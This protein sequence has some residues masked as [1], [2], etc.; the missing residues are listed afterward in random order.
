MGV[1]DRYRKRPAGGGVLSRY[2]KTPVTRE[3]TTDAATAVAEPPKGALQE[4]M[5][6]V[7]APVAPQPQPARPETTDVRLFEGQKAHTDIDPGVFVSGQPK[8]GDVDFSLLPKGIAVGTAD[9]VGRTIRGIE[10]QRPDVE[11]EN[12]PTP[13]VVAPTRV[14]T[15][16]QSRGLGYGLNFAT[17]PSRM[18]LEPVA[19]GKEE[20]KRKSDEALLRDYHKRSEAAIADWKKRGDARAQKAADQAKWVQGLVP[21]EWRVQVAEASMQNL[22]GGDT[23]S[24]NAW[25]ATVGQ[26]L[27]IIAEAF[28]AKLIGGTFGSV[29]GPGGTVAGGAAA[30]VGAMSLMESGAFMEAADALGIDIDIARKYAAVYGPGSGAIEYAQ[31]LWLGKSLGRM[32]KIKGGAAKYAIAAMKEIA[33]WTWEGVEELSQNTLENYF[34]QKAAGEHNL[35]HSDQPQIVAPQ[36]GEGGLRAFITG[37]G[38]AAITRTGGRAIGASGR[39]AAKKVREIRGGKKGTTDQTTEAQ[40]GDS[41][42]F[43]METMASV[44]ETVQDESGADL[45]E[46]TGFAGPAGYLLFHIDSRTPGGGGKAMAAK[47]EQEGLVLTGEKTSPVSQKFQKMVARLHQEGEIDIVEAHS[48]PINTH[49]GRIKQKGQASGAKQLRRILRNAGLEAGT[50]HYWMMSRGH[51]IPVKVVEANNIQMPKGWVRQG[52]AYVHESKISKT[53]VGV[54]GKPVA[55]T[56]QKAPKTPVP[57]KAP[58]RPLGAK[59]EET[60]AIPPEEGV[61]GEAKTPEQAR[62]EEWERQYNPP[63]TLQEQIAAEEAAE[64]ARAGQ[65][66]EGDGPQPDDPAAGYRGTTMEEWEAIASGGDTGTRLSGETWVHPDREYAEI[67]T[68][69][70]PSGRGVLIEYKPEARAKLKA[71]TDDSGD[72]RRMGKLDLGD[73]ARVFDAEGNVIYDAAEAEAEANERALGKAVEEAQAE[74]EPEGMPEAKSL[75]QVAREREAESR[76]VDEAEQK[77]Q[78]EIEPEMP[79]EPWQMIRD[80]YVYG[81]MAEANLTPEQRRKGAG[82]SLAQ[83]LTQEHY[84][85]VVKAAQEG[86]PVPPEVLAGFPELEVAKPTLQKKAA[87]KKPLGKKK[88]PKKRAESAQAAEKPHEMT[89][90]EYVE[91]HYE[92]HVVRFRDRPDVRRGRDEL[93]AEAKQL[94]VNAVG[95]A[96]ARGDTVSAEVLADYPALKKKGMAKR[97]PK[98]PLGKA[99]AVSTGEKDVSADRL[100]EVRRTGRRSER[101]TT[102]TKKVTDA[103]LTAT[104]KRV[105]GK[106]GPEGMELGFGSNP[107]V[108]A[109]AVNALS[110]AEREALLSLVDRGRVRVIRTYSPKEAERLV[111]IEPPAKKPLG[112]PK[113]QKRAPKKPAEPPRL[114]IPQALQDAFMAGWEAGTPEGN[115]NLSSSPTSDAYILGAFVKAEGL[116]GRVKKSRGYAWNVGDTV[117]RVEGD[118]VTVTTGEEAVTGKKLELTPKPTDATKPPDLGKK[119]KEVRE[120]VRESKGD[121]AKVVADAGLIIGEPK[122]TKKGK[123]YYPVT[124]NTWP[125][126]QMFDDLGAGKYKTRKGWVRSMWDAEPTEAIAAALQGAEAPDAGS[127]SRESSEEGQEARRPSDEDLEVQRNREREDGR[128]DRGSLAGD[129]SEFVSNETAALISKGLEFNIPQAIIDEQIEDVALGVQAY[130]RGSKLFMIASEPGTGKTYVLGGL[131]RELT[132]GG[133]SRVIYI[134][135]SQDLVS[136]I[137]KDLGGY[138]LENVDFFTYAGIRSQAVGEMA[139]AAVLFDEAHNIKNV[140]SQ[141]GSSGQ[142]ILKA[143]R[144]VVTA[145]ATPFENPVQAAYLDAAGVFDEVGGHHEWAKMYGATVITKKYFDYSKGQEVVEEYLRW[146]GGRHKQDDQ[147]AARNWFRKQGM[148]TQRGKTLPEGSVIS[149]FRK[150]SASAEYEQKYGG[151]LLAYEQAAKIAED[152]RAEPVTTAMISMH[153][154]NATKRLLEAAKIDQAIARTKKLM[155]DGKQVVI[156]TETKSFRHY[157]RFRKSGDT[158]GPLHTYPEMVEMMQEWGM[159]AEMARRMKERP[160]RRPFAEAIMYIAEAMH[161]LGIDYE[162]P[163]VVDKLQSEFDQSEV[164]WYVGSPTRT[165]AK[166]RKEMQ[167]WKAGKLKLLIATMAKGGTGLSLHDPSGTMPER[168]QVGVNLP[169][170]ATQVEQ[171]AGRLA[172]YGIVKPVTIE[173]LFAD[174]IQFER[175]LSNRVGRRMSDMGA[176]VKGVRVDAAAA[177]EDFNFE[178]GFDASQLSSTDES[179]L[180]PESSDAELYRQAEA[181]ERSRGKAEGTQGDFFETP[182]PVGVFMSRISGVR[183]GHRVLEPSAGR[184]NVV[185]FIGQVAGGDVTLV[186]VEQRHDNSLYLEKYFPGAEVHRGDFLETSTG[187]QFD[188]ILMNPP[189]SRMK[190]QGW[191]DINHVSEAYERLAPDGRLVSIM[192]IGVLQ[193]SDAQSVAFREWLDEVGAQVIHLPQDTFKRSG[194]SV[195]SIMV[196][197]DGQSDGGMDTIR[198]ENMETD[199]LLNLED[200]LTPRDYPAAPPAEQHIEPVAPEPQ[201]PIVKPTPLGKP[202]AAKPKTTKASQQ[203]IGRQRNALR[204]EIIHTW[205][206]ERGTSIDDIDNAKS[207]A[208]E[209]A[210]AN[211]SFY[212]PLPGEITDEVTVN[213]RIAPWVYQIFRWDKHNPV[214]K[215]GDAGGP[216]MISLYGGAGMVEVAKEILSGQAG[217]V[218]L[219]LTEA[220]AWAETTENVGLQLKIAQHNF[221]LDTIKTAEGEI[222]SLDASTLVTGD[223]FDVAGHIYTVVGVDGGG[224]ILIENGAKGFIYHDDTIP[225]RLGTFDISE[226]D[227][228]APMLENDEDAGDEP[229]PDFA[230]DVYVDDLW[231]ELE[232]LVGKTTGRFQELQGQIEETGK[233][234]DIVANLRSAIAKEKAWTKGSTV[235]PIEPTA[236]ETYLL[237]RPIARPLGGKPGTLIGKGE[238]IEQAVGEVKI[239]EELAR[240]AMVVM[241][242]TGFEIDTAEDLVIELLKHYKGQANDLFNNPTNPMPEANEAL[243]RVTKGKSL[244]DENAA[245]ESFKEGT[246]PPVAGGFLRFGPGESVRPRRLGDRSEGP[247]IEEDDPQ[248]VIYGKQK[249]LTSLQK[250]I[251]TLSNQSAKS[252]NPHVQEAGRLIVREPMKMANE[253]RAA[254]HHADS[255]YDSLPREY[256]RNRGRKFFELMDKE[257]TPED[258]EASIEIPPEVKSILKYFKNLDEEMRL[259]IIDRKRAMVKAM[260]MQLNVKAMAHAANEMGFDIA[261]EGGPQRFR[262]VDKDPALAALIGSDKGLPITKD[263]LSRRMARDKIPDSWGR[264]WA[265]IQHIFF[266]QYE[267]S[268]VDAE[269]KSHFIGRAE[270]QAEAF[271]KLNMFRRNPE[272]AHIPAERL[273][274]DPQLNLPIDVVRLSKGR[275]YH[276]VKDLKD[277]AQLATHEVQEALRGNVSKQQSKT[278]WWGALLHRKGMGG[279]SLDFKR[280]WSTQVGQFMR[281]KYLSDLNRAAVPHIEAVRSAGLRRWA[282][283]LQDWLDTLWGRNRSTMAQ[284]L[285]E[286]LARTP[287]LKWYVRPFALERWLGLAKTVNYWRHLQTGRFYVIN[288]L[289]PFQTLWP[290]VGTRGLMAAIY[291]YYTPTGRALLRKYHVKEQIGKLHEGSMTKIPLERFTPAGASE[292]RNQ[293]LAFLALYYKAKGLGMGDDPAADYAR[294]RGQIMTQFAYSPADVPRMARGP[295]GGLI[296][297]YRRF[298]IKNLELLSRLWREGKYGG[299]AKW[300]I[301]QTALGGLKVLTFGMGGMYMYRLWK[302]LNDRYG[303]EMAD[304]VVYGVPSL[305]GVDMGGSINVVD[306]PYGRSTPEKIGNA[307]LG[308][309][310]QTVVRALGDLAEDRRSK[311]MGTSEILLDTAIRTSPTVKQFRY[312]IQAIEKDTS[313]YNAKQQRQYELETWDLWKKAFGFRAVTESKQR[314]QFEALMWIK[315]KYDAVLN[316]AVAELLESD[317]EA[318]GW[319]KATAA[320][321]EKLKEWNTLWPDFPVTLAALKQRFISRRR[322]RVEPLIKRGLRNSPKRVRAAFEQERGEKKRNADQ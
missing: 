232:E 179:P 256:R 168:V 246:D 138:G 303:E 33:G 62:M 78:E 111:V 21:H 191:Q 241:K 69:R 286:V 149:T 182:Y 148:F 87:K 281:W 88:Q 230:A 239:K 287:V 29:L 117:I 15:A 30:G 74:R 162:L 125:H 59:K 215:P 55:K 312:L 136:Q 54:T 14:R 40:T 208:E 31:M 269:G 46:M 101:P 201:I 167:A 132:A 236:G 163:S 157:G 150:A 177:L 154:A 223:K 262:L 153:A 247:L 172:R 276:L 184:G 39:A 161:N 259:E 270:T 25:I 187:E 133:I 217:A 190:G 20:E 119:P 211:F 221:M 56:P 272:N 200:E 306:I 113:A 42:K 120:E 320:A 313:N 322:S 86:K 57:E 206:Y 207:Q 278:K 222:E 124:G 9:T 79:L 5:D 321:S 275:Y 308:P 181:L 156:F 319:P 249:D 131:I 80:D 67:Y 17:G 169:W 108:Y 45:A 53:G 164:G 283:H 175:D 92:G 130:R 301:A 205:E 1:L 11:L 63:P 304:T 292:T 139:N 26:Q 10:A 264:Q 174:N 50:Y 210:G 229:V 290:V 96:V 311:P 185:R 116:T 176:L 27:P 282:D 13:S 126:K 103:P 24:I 97:K 109:K 64:E 238:M 284:S 84:D 144:F 257:L 18:A 235:K 38:V 209:A 147:I 294:E 43:S 227:E 134:T 183:P 128:P 99:K 289:Q 173:W 296:L 90:A 47:V 291:R 192:G 155:N 107:L 193:H 202:K 72:R 267:L 196:I 295:V 258:I 89:Q 199:S 260:Y 245:R 19:K 293:G 49:E 298:S 188:T 110:K 171:V 4:S 35:R 307:V 58:H 266:G 263:S 102:W 186:M 314:A 3:A 228:D 83:K 52:D 160:P 218:R 268:W 137:K 104:E 288:S 271:E 100:D 112:K 166:A 212:G 213:G 41:V 135:T 216:E 274:A 12:V 142:Q 231:T 37:V 170:T 129:H 123:T 77:A 310:G 277:S 93:V 91:H 195:N 75:G 6:E 73:V 265:H 178:D 165:A 242:G 224:A 261:V 76:A 118:E 158:K 237:G 299:V 251:L 219:A 300:L 7:T 60:A 28:G 98:K 2:R 85:A 152:A 285:D 244:F 248:I 81:K 36:L 203:K 318:D 316:D 114:D 22:L 141:Q 8:G 66:D 16:D 273:I 309:T 159:E 255:M 240:G 317:P 252:D 127:V 23:K 197:I 198:L 233:Y 145:S 297:Q 214:A 106:I 61:S 220:A 280:V 68:R 70:I 105:L 279:Y 115:P 151:L 143:A 48:V 121:A 226:R 302:W 51:S 146:D 140:Q 189:F 305:V 44:E 254:I 234:D 34:L 32:N 315:D 194:T 94:H 180:V 71:L 122:T 65:A 95:Q 253:Y 82:T 250:H 243:L 204:D 225:I